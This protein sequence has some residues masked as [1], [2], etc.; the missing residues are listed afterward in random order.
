MTNNPRE[1]AISKIAEI[2]KEHRDF[3]TTKQ[4]AEAILD[5]LNIEIVSKE[6]EPQQWLAKLEAVDFE[7]D[8]V[9]F[10]LPSNFK[11]CKDKYTIS[12]G[13]PAVYVENIGVKL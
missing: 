2:I 1:Q 3:F 10:E 11:V 13:K 6:S 5:A 9:Q 4:T 7:N 12:K 8:F